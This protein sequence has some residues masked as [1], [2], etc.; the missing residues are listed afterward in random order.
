MSCI[1]CNQCLQINNN[2]SDEVWIKSDPE[3]SNHETILTH[4]FNYFHIHL[5]LASEYWTL[6]ADD[7]PFCPTCEYMAGK[8]VD[9]KEKL[10]IVKNDL[11][12]TERWMKSQI[13]KISR[14]TGC[15][16]LSDKQSREDARV[17]TIRDLIVGP[18]IRLTRLPKTETRVRNY[19]NQPKAPSETGGKKYRRLSRKKIK[20]EVDTETFSKPDVLNGSQ[21][22]LC[23]TAVGIKKLGKNSP[24]KKTVTSSEGIEET[25]PLE[26]LEGVS[27]VVNS[28]EQILLDSQNDPDNFTDLIVLKGE[29]VTFELAFAKTVDSSDFRDENSVVPELEIV[30][31]VPRFCHEEIVEEVPKF[32]HEEIVGG[33]DILDLETDPLQS[34]GDSV[35]EDFVVSEG[36]ETAEAEEEERSDTET[37]KYVGLKQ[38]GSCNPFSKPA[39]AI[40]KLE[41]EDRYLYHDKLEFTG[42]PTVGYQCIKCS[43]G[44]NYAN[45]HGIY[46]HLRNHLRYPDRSKKSRTSKEKV[47]RIDGEDDRYI[48]DGKLEFM[49][50]DQSGY[51]CSLCPEWTFPNQERVLRHFLIHLRDTTLGN[52]NTK[53]P[54]CGKVLVSPG[55]LKNHIKAHDDSSKLICEVCGKYCKTVKA[56]GCHM[57]FNHGKVEFHE[58]DICGKKIRGDDSHLRSHKNSVHLKLK[59]WCCEFCGKGFSYGPSLQRHLLSAAHSSEKQYSCDVCGEQFRHL[60]SKIKHMRRFHSQPSDNASATQQPDSEVQDSDEDVGLKSL[61]CK[62]CGLKYQRN[63]HLTRHLAQIHGV[64]SEK[65]Q[66]KLGKRQAK[67]VTVT[68]T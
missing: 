23:T 9:L 37:K 58:C 28:N 60:L 65:K 68:D 2:A 61:R 15:S 34:A 51:N 38:Q 48:F 42:N 66:P 22:E 56:L 55:G 29:T 44:H 5:P 7:L 53:C 4:F 67:A 50:N 8:L 43:N 14:S 62:L 36:E 57:R 63:C 49:G 47:K 39:R 12:V 27:E 45:R 41:G 54:I 10:E 19:N 24:K 16:D 3:K 13:K 17:Q 32:C 40:K 46:L 18:V 59:K 26:L 52:T 64:V 11:A 1:I 30:E 20:S 35:D 6:T 33:D 25:K 21:T 31:E